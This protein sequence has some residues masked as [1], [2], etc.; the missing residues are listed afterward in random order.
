MV[1]LSLLVESS[2]P[3]FLEDVYF[4]AIGFILGVVFFTI[5]GGDCILGLPGELF[6]LANYLI[7][8]DAKG[9]GILDGVNLVLVD[10]FCD[11]LDR[12]AVHFAEVV[13]YFEFGGSVFLQQGEVEVI[14]VLP[15]NAAQMKLLFSEDALGED[16]LLSYHLKLVRRVHYK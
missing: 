16:A 5:V 10:D 7:F 4:F 11:F 15:V 6:R 3:H 8:G 14:L 9:V 13:L 2:S 1:F 12:V